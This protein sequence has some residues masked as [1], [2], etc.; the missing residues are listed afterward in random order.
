[1]PPTR[2]EIERN[3]AE[4]THKVL[5][6]DFTGITQDSREVKPGY[7]F[8]ALPG[9][10]VDGRDFIPQALEM[11]AT[12]IIAQTG[13]LLPGNKRKI[14]LIE[15]DN[16]H[17]RFSQICA[18]YYKDQ[19]ETIAAVTGTNGKTSTAH[20][21]AQLW[22]ALG[23]KSASMG[24][25]G[26]VKDGK[27]SSSSSLTTP[28]PV[29]LHKQLAEL[30]E[31][32][33]THLCMEAS[34]H[35][36]EQ[37]RLDGVRL[38]VAGYTNLSRDHLDYHAD[39]ESYLAAKLR[40]FSEV[41]RKGGTVVLNADAP[42]YEK[43]LKTSRKAGHTIL[44]YGRKGEDIRLLESNLHENG[45]ALTLEIADKTYNVPLPLV[46]EFQAMNALCALG[47][48]WAG[49]RERLDHIL[50]AL[51]N[52]EPVP[53]RLQKI[54]GPRAV[55]VDYA[56]TPD[57]LETVLKALRPHAKGKLICLFGCGGDRDPGKRP[58]MGESAARLADRVIVTDDNP[59]SEKPESIRA[60]ILKGIERK[61]G[62]TEIGD[63]REAIK[64]AMKQ[65]EPKDVLLV[66]GKGHETGQII[67]S[68]TLPF[69]D[70]QEVRNAMPDH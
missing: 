28:D 59:R 52:L 5:S 56:H 38:A 53:G 57:A 40:L 15:S 44:S 55:Y 8:A 3:L 21:T 33:I 58:L 45:Q 39:M 26:L 24:T 14:L 22:K 54:S 27:A 31:E 17:Q 64:T 62:V 20:F 34:S 70:A 46:G 66:A 41:L 13:T 49:E 48:V 63:R 29:T 68:E 69:D 23:Y 47:L 6:G 37:Y 10:R 61:E 25:L 43:L 16:P 1:M 4:T 50:K 67:G 2:T 7:I 11:G 42:E 9:T 65:M 32:G 12:G 19:P 30:T 18:A 36:L 51:E 35:G 60:A